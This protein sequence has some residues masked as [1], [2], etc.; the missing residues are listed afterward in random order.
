MDVLPS[1]EAQGIV[2]FLVSSWQWLGL[3][4][5]LQ[6]DNALDFGGPNR[7]PRSFGRVVRVAVDLGLEPVFNP[8]REP[9]RNGG[10]ERHNGFL[11]DRLFT[12]ECPDLAALRQQTYTCQTA[13][14][15]TSFSY[16]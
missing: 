7:Y 14:N 3:P 12:I 15:H 9:W 2:N 4:Q 16:T 6:M 11:Q 8:P 1:R 5:S 13:C 10:V